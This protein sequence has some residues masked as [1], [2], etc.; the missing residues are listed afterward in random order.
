[1]DRNRVSRYPWQRAAAEPAA[2]FAPPGFVACPGPTIPPTA[3]PLW[4][5]QQEIFRRAY[6]AARAKQMATLPFHHRLFSNW[7]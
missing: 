7:N 6:E 1:M 3:A 5:W 4:M 2:V